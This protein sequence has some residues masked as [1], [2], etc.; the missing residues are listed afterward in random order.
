MVIRAIAPSSGIHASATL[1]Y[2]ERK[3]RIISAKDA[4]FD[5]TET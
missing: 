3:I 4:A 5:A 2:T 1:P